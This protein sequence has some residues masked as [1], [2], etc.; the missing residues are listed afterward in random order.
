[1]F[2]VKHLLFF[3]KSR[4]LHEWLFLLFLAT[5]FFQT[6]IIYFPELAY[7]GSY[8]SYPKAIMVYL[9]DILFVTALL[10]WL[11]FTWNKISW[12]PV[13]FG[14]PFLIIGGIGLFHVEHWQ[15]SVF[16][17]VKWI[18]LF[19]ISWYIWNN[20]HSPI[21]K[22]GFWVIFIALLFQAGL[23]L[24]QFHVNGEVGLNWLG[25]YVPDPNSAGAAT[26]EINGFKH[27]RGYGT[28]PHPNVLAG[29]LVFGL[30]MG[31][32]SVSR[33][34]KLKWLVSISTIFITLGLVVTLSRTAWLAALV[35]TCVLVAIN[36]RQ[37]SKNWLRYWIF[38]AIVSCGTMAIMYPNI[39]VNRSLDS[40]SAS[41]AYTHRA[42]YNEAGF[43]V[44][45]AHPWF[46][47]GPG[48]YIP[49]MEQVFHVEQWQYQPPHNVG[50]Y[51][52]AEFGILGIIALTLTI[53]KT[54]R[55]T[56]N[57]KVSWLALASIFALIIL[58]TLDHY[59]ISIQPGRLTLFA[60]IPLILLYQDVSQPV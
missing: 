15:I 16:Q 37:S 18:E 51:L 11:G 44:F 60:I 29:S 2:H 28:F 26:F 7:I 48:N 35:G 36:L 17:L 23:A 3:V 27:I 1:M 14:L 57:K 34:T 46:G 30:L 33:E 52:L 5:A 59:L 56:W 40:G 42:F 49:T 10:T 6:R 50:I 58:F 39:L 45:Q 21:V 31:L 25:E 24:A 41:Q 53:V 54:L 9:N 8:F 47:T 55:F 32:Y 13:L 43:K 4:P 22:I 38:I 20:R 19:A 12:K